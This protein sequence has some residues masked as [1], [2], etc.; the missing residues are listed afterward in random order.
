LIGRRIVFEEWVGLGGEHLEAGLGFQFG[1]LYKHPRKHGLKKI[2]NL[3]RTRIK[4]QQIQ[5]K[6]FHG[7]ASL[8]FFVKKIELFSNVSQF[9]SFNFNKYW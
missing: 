4:N 2:I 9:Y 7:Q 3:L 8:I 5:I 1:I 6:L